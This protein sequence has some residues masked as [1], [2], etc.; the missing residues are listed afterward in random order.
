MKRY[1]KL[2]EQ[3]SEIDQFIQACQASSEYKELLKWGYQIEW[4]DIEHDFSSYEKIVYILKIR[5]ESVE[6]TDPKLNTWLR[7]RA[8]RDYMVRIKYYVNKIVLDEVSR[9]TLGTDMN[10]WEYW[11][12]ISEDNPGDRFYYYDTEMQ[13]RVDAVI[14]SFNRVLEF[15]RKLDHRLKNHVDYN[16]RH[17]GYLLKHGDP[18]HEDRRIDR[19]TGDAINGLW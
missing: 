4:K 11:N 5:P 10:G 2:F 19:G 16:N 9:T 17:I 14:A 3:F 8:D 7:E 15:T 6:I 1:V 18:G 12:I 13:E